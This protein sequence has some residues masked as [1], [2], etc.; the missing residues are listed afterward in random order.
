M[1][2]R[3]DVNGVLSDWLDEQAGR[4]APAYLGEI[5]ARTT[6]TRQRPAW[7][8][9]ERWLPV[10]MTF[11]GRLA[12]IPRLAWFAAV[13][14][15]LVLAAAALFVAGVGQRRLPH[16]GA[17]ANGQ[18]A[19]IDGGNLKVA[20][21]DGSNPR[22][23]TPLPDGAEQL[24][25]APDGT[26]LAYRT[27]GTVPSIVVA[28]A[29]GSDPV[30]VA[31]GPAIGTGD[32]LAWSPDSGRL[33]FTNVIVAD[34]IGTIDVVNADGSHRRQV[35]QGPAAEGV[36]RYRPAWSPDGQ[37]ISYFATEPAGYVA[38]HVIHPDGGG[39][40]RLATSPMNPSIIDASWSPD[41]A[42]TRVVYVT[43]GYVKMFDLRTAQ[44]TTIGTGFWP[45]WSPDG[46]RIAWW[47]DRVQ[48][49][50]VADLLAGIG[51]PVTLFPWYGSGNCQDH[52]EAAGKSNCGPAQWSPDGAWVYAPDV[53]GTSILIAR[54]DGSG[55]VRS[56]K[57]DH[58]IDLENGSGGL[59]AWQ[60]VAP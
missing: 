51:R 57:L 28:N 26:K 55:Q 16:F 48:A 24:A 14:A 15:M 29:D 25:F 42:T 6:R 45:T 30:I 54:S 35:I 3:N 60:A 37:W 8:S 27:T 32:P 58:P 17:A 38:L 2:A 52:P 47:G 40:Q 33:A 22:T 53:V 21:A 39:E 34:R 49:V 9:L 44:E 31:T 23:L 7:S 4:G 5:L 36:D 18:I 1:T 46:A 50:N 10:Q 59:L 11:S 19:F 20:A 12:P 43:G 41:P 13:L 56:I